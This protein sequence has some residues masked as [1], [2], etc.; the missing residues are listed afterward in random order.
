ML[1]QKVNDY[2]ENSQKWKFIQIDIQLNLSF[3]ATKIYNKK[4][5]HKGGGH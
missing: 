1:M 5:P 4:W 2:T 3:T